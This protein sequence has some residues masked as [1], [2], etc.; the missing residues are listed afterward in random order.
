MAELLFA[1]L[2]TPLL[3][4]INLLTKL[5]FWL[6]GCGVNIA[7]YLIKLTIKVIQKG[8]RQFRQIRVDSH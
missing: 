5:L 7:Y 8:Y 4:I 3:V 1:L 2:V 6:V